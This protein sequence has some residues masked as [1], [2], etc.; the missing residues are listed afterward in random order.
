MP[1]QKLLDQLRN[2][3]RFKH[4]SLETEK[5]YVKWVKDFVLFHHVQHPANMGKEEIS[6]FLTHLAVKRNVAASTQNQALCALLFLYREVLELEVG[7]LEDLEH[8][9]KPARLPVVFTKDEARTVLVHLDGVRRLMACLLYGSG[10]RLK[11]CV[12]LRIKDVDYGQNHIVV[13]QAKG[14]KDRVTVLP[15]SLKADLKRQMAKVEALHNKDRAEGFGRVYLPY[16]LA[17]KYPAAELELGWQYVFPASKRSVDPRSGIERRHHVDE[18]VLQRAVKEAIRKAGIHKH[19][20]CHTFRHSFATHLLE[21]GYDIRTVQELLGHSDVKT[22]MI[23]THVL[24][25]GAA[26]VRSP[27]DI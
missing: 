3:L 25:R 19:A 12:R 4:Y 23:Y 6:A 9:K 15:D 26:G 7:W 21:N 8:A 5:A 27:I 14:Q 1:E 17:K 2:R 18:S 20:S 22:T 11:E 16:A 10:L 24:N 13:R